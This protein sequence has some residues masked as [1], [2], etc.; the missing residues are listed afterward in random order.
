MHAA[1]KPQSSR[2]RPIESRKKRARKLRTGG[3]ADRGDEDALD[4]LTRGGSN[5]ERFAQRRNQYYSMIIGFMN[6][7]YRVSTFFIHISNPFLVCKSHHLE[8][9]LVLNCPLKNIIEFHKEFHQFLFPKKN[10]SHPV[11][12]IET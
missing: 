4:P 2:R 3:R 12:R 11:N 9:Y 5:F 8:S 1:Q 10:S 7:D 6:Y